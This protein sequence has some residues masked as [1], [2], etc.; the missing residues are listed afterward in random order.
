MSNSDDLDILLSQARQAIITLLCHH[1]D[2]DRY[3]CVL[4]L[5]DIEDKL[6]KL[7]IQLD[8]YT[9]KSVDSPRS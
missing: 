7:G 2:R 1:D 5:K 6:E 3:G 4:V 9:K 8:R